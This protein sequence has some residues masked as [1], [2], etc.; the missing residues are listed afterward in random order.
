MTWPHSESDWEPFLPVVEPVF[1]ALAA[2]IAKSERLLITVHNEQVASRALNYLTQAGVAPAQYQLVLVCSDDI[3]TRDYGPITIIE[4]GNPIL[5][6]FR[7][8]GWGAKYSATQDDALNK[9][10][11]SAG[12]FGN[13]P[14]QR[15]NLVLEGGSID[16]DG[17]GTL[18]TTESCLLT[19]T[20]NPELDQKSW[21]AELHAHFGIER[22]LW[23]RHGSIIGDDTDGHIDTLA[24]FCS[25]ELIAYQSCNDPND[26]NFLDLQEM[27]AELINLQQMN[28]APYRLAPLPWPRPHYAADGRRLPATYANF[29]II[30]NAVLVPQYNDP[31]DQDTLAILQKCFPGREIIGINC[32]PLI[33]QNGS[34]HC[35]TMQLPIE[36]QI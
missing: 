9:T 22:V 25:P 21:E 28:G 15:I 27:A 13:T 17:Q 4:N 1:A 16:G 33:L 24:R 31:A 14:L 7:F 10:L 19:P 12:I 36:V 29:L 35:V 30:N 11:H 32:A 3:W 34:L 8:N 5:L 23:L 18:L 2:A 26:D 20:R 6:D